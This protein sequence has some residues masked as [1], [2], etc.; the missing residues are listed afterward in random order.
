MKPPDPGPALLDVFS[1]DAT[2]P[3]ISPP[4][5]PEL[6]GPRSRWTRSVQR[7]A[8]VAAILG[9]LSLAFFLA[10]LA[11]PSI[12]YY[13]EGLYVPEA[14]AFAHWQIDPATRTH[15]LARPPFGK[16]LMAA[17][18]RVA[19]DTPF[20]WRVGSAICG[21]LTL[22][23]VYFWTLLLLEDFRSALLA[24]VLTLLNN[25]LFVMSRVGMLDSFFLLFL[26]WSLVAYT[27]ALVLDISSWKRQLLVGVSGVLIGLAAAV[28]WNA[29]DTLTV[30][31][32]LSA[33][34][35]VLARPSRAGSFP[36]L[37][38]LARNAQQIGVPAFFLGLFVV[39][40]VT[41]AL[42]YWPLCSILGRPF[43]LA[44]LIN[45]HRYT[46]Y[47][48]TRW[49]TNKAITSA[50]YTWPFSLSPQ[51][52]L[53]YLL[54]NP[55]VAWGGI[56]ALFV[57]L[58]RFWQTLQF[59][60]ALVLLLFGANFF[61]WAVTPEKGLVYYYYYPAAMTLGV[62]I[63][64]ALRSLPFR[65]FHIRISLIVLV[66]AAAVFLWCYPRMAHLQAPWDCALGCWN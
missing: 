56:A 40:G 15:N 49:K 20:G 25:F 55:V 48:S 1:A 44:E 43:N 53:S 45:L 46:W 19:G 28:K 7:P 64:V 60:E 36:S 39:P 33:A 42:T 8:L 16:L 54:A 2:V 38:R 21:A 65:V 10:G 62:A 37:S 14:R 26:L 66:L 59:P 50:W 58:K 9:T 41:Y 52:G 24:A 57:C 30:F 4:L 47:L 18:I 6:S 32:L 13:D 63:V 22:V 12:M 29:V 3:S 23:A 5:S 27:A 17:A 31:V 34:L 61:Q 35:L 11:R 51:R